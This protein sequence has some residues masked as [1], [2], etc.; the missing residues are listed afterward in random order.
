MREHRAVVAGPDP[1]TLIDPIA[2]DELRRAMADLA[3]LWL[4]PLR[5][6]PQPLQHRGPLTYTVLTLCRMLYTLR[7][8]VVPSKPQAARWAEQ[9]Q[10]GRWSPLIERALAWR[11]APAP[12]DPVRDDER[13]DALA[14]LAYTMDQCRSLSRSPGRPQ[15]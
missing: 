7:W 8:G 13:R 3:D 10:E 15:P 9:V 4:T 5:Q 1:R 14:L 6:K 2:P 11:K 12:Q